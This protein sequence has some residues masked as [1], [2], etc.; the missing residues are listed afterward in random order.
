MP[1]S[2]SILREVREK[3]PEWFA[4]FFYVLDIIAMAS[5][6]TAA[7]VA[8]SYS[9]AFLFLMP[10]IFFNGILQ[11]ERRRRSRE[12]SDLEVRKRGIPKY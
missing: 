8:K 9:Y 11:T 6:L 7:L 3:L 2:Q 1:S 10:A 5:L 4:F 12:H